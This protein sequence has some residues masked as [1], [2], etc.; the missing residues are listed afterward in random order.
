MLKFKNRVRLS[1]PD[2]QKKNILLLLG[3]GTFCFNL[4]ALLLIVFNSSMVQ[5]LSRQLTPQV[6]VELLDG[7]AITADSEP[8]LQRQPQT[9]RRFVGE[10]LTF[11]LT[12]SS[13][14]PPA[15]I[16][17]VSSDLLMTDFQNQFYQEFFTKNLDKSLRSNNQEPERIFV[18][19]TISQ[20]V[21]IAPGKWKV[22]IFANQLI[23]SNSN[24][25]GKSIP[26]NQQILV[27]AVE[28]PA[29]S[30]PDN[31]VSWHLVAYRLGEARL[32]IYKICGLED[33]KCFE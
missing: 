27:R 5:Q 33:K 8:N 31:P 17:E 4:F 10:T 19:Q 16:W 29:I 6:L 22:E 9:I 18:I 12:T 15:T 13:E 1:Q 21:E 3:I 23:F 26:F 30:R 28:K 11:M 2:H 32:Q 20:P 24:N 25:L 7:R 14:Q